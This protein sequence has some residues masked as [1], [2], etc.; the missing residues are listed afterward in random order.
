MPAPIDAPLSRIRWTN[1]CRLIPSRY[2]SVGVFD[3]IAAP[4]D[5]DALIELEAWTNDRVSA[6]LGILN[7]LPRE[8]WVVGQPMASV[9]MAAFCHPSPDGAR[10][11]DA[12]RGAWYAGRTL[13]T[14]LAESVHRRTRELAEVG[15][16]ETRMQM[17]LYHA[18]IRASFHDIR[19]P[20]PAYLPL[21]APDSYK[22]SQAFARRLFEEEGSDGILYRSVR[23]PGGE[24][25]ACFR[26]KLV[27]NVRVAA[28]YEYQ[29]QGTPTPTV[30][31]LRT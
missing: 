6:E 19:E 16:F 3:R 9:V 30:R 20:R 15:H 14:S 28:H 13:D 25:V 23:H 11:S 29:W 22:A 7:L 18:D 21:Y 10:F 4:E 8:E 17:R 5:L 1:T 24:C 2:P 27:Q 12:R 31:R 26:P